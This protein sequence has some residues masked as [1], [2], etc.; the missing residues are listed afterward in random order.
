MHKQNKRTAGILAALL[1]LGQ[2]LP[3]PAAAAK[4]KTTAVDPAPTVI[5]AE[6]VYFNDTSGDMSAQGNVKIVQGQDV[7]LTEAMRGNQKQTMVWVDGEATLLQPE[8]RLTGSGLVYNYSARTGSVSQ[9]R[10]VMSEP[11]QLDPLPGRVKQKQKF[12]TGEQIDLSPGYVAAANATYTGCDLK[13]PDYHI[14]ADKVE[15]WPG[16]K[17]IAHNARFWIGSTVVYSMSRYEKSLKTNDEAP[18]FPSIGYS[19]DN[20]VYIRQRLSKPLGNNWELYTNLAYYSKADFRPQYGIGWDNAGY[21][22]QVEAGDYYDG[23]VWLEKQPEFRFGVDKRRIGSLP[24][25]YQFTAVYGKWK[26]ADKT[27]WHQEYSLYF[28]GDPIVLDAAKT[29]TLSLGTGFS[30][31]HESYDSSSDTIWRYDAT[32][33]KRW[34]PKLYTFV[35]QHY[36]DKEDSVFDYDDPDVYNELKSGVVYTID[37]RSTLSYQQ[38]YDLDSNELFSRTYGWNYSMHCWDLDFSHTNYTDDR[39]DRWRVKVNTDF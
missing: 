11:E 20:G 34:S 4:D 32:L 26:E 36:V 1:A 37:K 13:T 8:L 5:E 19:S 17:M 35:G 16:D 21:S 39:S 31:I 38:S 9:A 12:L 3:L 23:D 7:I 25:S 33:G 29:L 15:I 14:S 27:S 22:F 2:M 6:R 24:V 10:S 18:A 30:Y 28:S